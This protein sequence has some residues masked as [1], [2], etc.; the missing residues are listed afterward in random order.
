MSKI[1]R[2]EADF[3]L[4][5][6]HRLTPANNMQTLF[7][8]KIHPF[9][10]INS[11][12][13]P[14]CKHICFGPMPSLLNTEEFKRWESII[15]FYLDAEHWCTLEIYP[16]DWNAIQQSSLIGYHRFILLVKLSLANI[17]NVGYNTCIV[18]DDAKHG[19]SNGGVWTHEVHNLR[20]REYFTRWDEF[21]GDTPR[22]FSK[23]SN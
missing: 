15:R 2:E 7:M 4:G 21:N 18:I 19:D 5:R 10:T 22:K 8:S 17:N 12:K 13:Q 6:E 20:K 3:I 9:K 11:I 16:E 1:S 23:Q 14:H